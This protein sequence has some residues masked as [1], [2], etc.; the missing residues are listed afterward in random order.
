MSNSNVGETI[1]LLQEAESEV[2]LSLRNGLNLLN[3]FR[4]CVNRVCKEGVFVSGSCVPVCCFG[5][6]GLD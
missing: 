4:S 6:F 3:R 2:S 5:L 1:S